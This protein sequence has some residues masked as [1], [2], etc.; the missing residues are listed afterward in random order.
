MYE[1]DKELRKRLSDYPFSQIIIEEAMN[2][3]LESISKCT[4]SSFTDR[5][6]AIGAIDLS[7]KSIFRRSNFPCEHKYWNSENKYIGKAEYNKENL[8]YNAF[9]LYTSI[10]NQKSS[11]FI[12]G[13]K[14]C[15]ENYDQS[16]KYTEKKKNRVYILFKVA[17]IV[18]SLFIAYL[19]ASNGRYYI[20]EQHG[21]VIDKWK[22]EII[23]W[24]DLK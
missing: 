5:E 13:A 16:F 9:K 6:T 20:S 2:E 17:V 3:A 12:G 15:M 21:L 18:A 11:Y 1:L 23:S 10:D 4:D 19:W 22:Q 14:F 24:G 8:D 7:I